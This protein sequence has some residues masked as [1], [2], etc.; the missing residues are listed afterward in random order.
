MM[1]VEEN[2]RLT[3]VG[4]GTPMGNLLRRYWMPIAIS[5]EVQE[6]PVAKRLLGED[7][8]VFRGGDG[9]V[10]VFDRHCP[11]RRADLA[12]GVPEEHGLR[13]GYHG[14]MFSPDGQCIVQPAELRLNPRMKI[15]AYPAEELGGLVW[16]YMGPQP[17][18]LLPPFDLFVWNDVMRD[19]GH[20]MLDFNWLQAME[21]SVDPHHVEWLHGRFMNFHRKLEQ[22]EQA[23]VL[24][25]K[26]LKVGFDAFEFGIIKRRVL[27][28]CTEEDD[29]WKIGHPLVFPITLRV[30]GGGLDQFQIRVPIDDTHTWHIWYTTYRTGARHAPQASVPSYVVPLFDASGNRILDFVDGQDI[31]AWAGQGTIADRTQEHLAAS[32]V[33]V[34][35]LRRMLREQLDRVEKGLDPLGTVRDPEQNRCIVLPMEKNKY[36]SGEAFRNELMQFQ[37]IRHSPIRDEVRRLYAQGAKLAAEAG[38]AEA[39]PA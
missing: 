39:T 3:R 6:R 27:E 19:I 37:A 14:W 17:A 36:G 20:A 35:L 8:V 9:K 15:K 21:N 34:A 10:G 18:P 24:T 12:V 4:P 29:D 25:K 31:A 23:Q 30:G 26:H 11:H 32:D 5:A 28:G 38:S 22:S 7:L 33:G 1:T 13:C 2:D 16:A